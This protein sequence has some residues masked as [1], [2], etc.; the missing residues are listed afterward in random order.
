MTYY[1][2]VA[3]TR[4]VRPVNTMVN[5]NV[6]Q[7]NLSSQGLIMLHRNN[8]YSNTMR[9]CIYICKRKHIHWM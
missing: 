3:V 1:A 5:H 6:R 7:R 4:H 2:P 9:P 8:N